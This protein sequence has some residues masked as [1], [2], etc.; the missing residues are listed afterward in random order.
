MKE[1]PAWRGFLG[2]CIFR[3]LRACDRNKKVQRKEETNGSKGGT[4]MVPVAR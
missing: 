4:D 2:Y 1:I 3:G